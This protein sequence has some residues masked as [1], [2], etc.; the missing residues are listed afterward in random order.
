MMKPYALYIHGMGSGAKSGTKSSLGH[1]LSDYEWISPEVTHNPEES[2]AILNDWAQA[3]QPALIAGTSMGGF[4]NLYIDCPS[5][6]KLIVNPTYNIEN[7]MRKVGYGKHKYHCEREN[8]ETEYVIDEPLVRSFINYRTEHQ[9]I[10]GVRNIAVFSSDD[11]LVG[12]ENAK[13]NAAVLEKAG[14]EVYWSDKFGHRLNEKVAKKIVE[15][16]K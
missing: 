16:L 8:G 12:K 6:V 5:A 14:F 3:F 15:W 13:K 4:Y 10:L 1:Y 9:I 2:L 7:V 11:E